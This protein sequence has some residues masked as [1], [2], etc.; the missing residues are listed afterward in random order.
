MDINS[1]KQAV[2]DVNKNGWRNCKVGSLEILLSLASLV[3]GASIVENR[4]TQCDDLLC[5]GG[6]EHKENVAWNLRGEADRLL[7]S[8]VM[9][10]LPEIIR[11]L[12]DKFDN[13]MMMCKDHSDILTKDIVDAIKK[14][15]GVK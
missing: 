4:D 9:A 1:V 5:S 13:G 12:F 2:E 3:V 8:K 7:W 10:R 11:P 14:E 6:C 15:L